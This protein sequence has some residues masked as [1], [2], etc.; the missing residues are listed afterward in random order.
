MELLNTIKKVE[1]SDQLYARIQSRI[2]IQKQ[3]VIAMPKVYAIAASILLIIGVNILAITS[4]YNQSSTQIS[5]FV[6]TQNTLYN[7]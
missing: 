5:T 6:D 3:N 7:E 1:P 4:N 2:E